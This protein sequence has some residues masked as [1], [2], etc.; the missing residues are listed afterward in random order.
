MADRLE[1]DLGGLTALA[2]R[3][4][5][6]RTTLQA[7]RGGIDAARGDLGSAEVAQ[8][9]D[10]FEHRWRDG[11]DKIDKNATTLTTMLR[12][13][14]TAYHA[15]DGQLTASLAAPAGSGPGAPG[16]NG[17]ATSSVGPSV[18]ATPGRPGGVAR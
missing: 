7:T 5:G 1:V 10:G 3:L 6:I 18:G 4:D 14:V 8:A 11:R 2:D 15:A 13:S 9:L 16:S 12:A 17:R